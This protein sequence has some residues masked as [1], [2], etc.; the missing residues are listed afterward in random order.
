MRKAELPEVRAERQ[1]GRGAFGQSRC[2]GLNP[3][4]GAMELC[5]AE[6]ES[7]NLG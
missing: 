5:Q 6:K 7:M 1:S 2:L 4:L 3:Q